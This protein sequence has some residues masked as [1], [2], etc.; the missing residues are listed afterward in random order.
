MKYT[1]VTVVEGYI[2]FSLKIN[3]TILRASWLIAAELYTLV[4]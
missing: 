4:A 3:A 2:M 1:E